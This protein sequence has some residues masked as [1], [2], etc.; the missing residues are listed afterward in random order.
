M[1]QKIMECTVPA[2]VGKT[3]RRNHTDGWIVLK[4]IPLAIHYDG[5]RYT[6]KETI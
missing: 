1:Y 5:L 2:C 4:P 6:K 3:L